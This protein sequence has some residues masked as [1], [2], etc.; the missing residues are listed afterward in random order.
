VGTDETA[1]YL[2][3]VHS[4]IIGAY[5]A[6]I[7]EALAFG[8]K[9]GLDIAQ[10]VDVLEAGPLGSRQL[11]LKAP[12]LK[13]RRFADP[14]SDID[15]AAKDVDM[16]LETARRDSMPLPVLS[17]VRQIM[18]AAQAVGGGKRDIY[19]I[20]ETFEQMGGIGPVR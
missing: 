10:I 13:S 2:K 16:I 3:L 12:V 4:L 8:E 6:L 18:A 9:G 7:G 11:S 20:L 1:A 17:A 5:S 14:P 19:S 15:T